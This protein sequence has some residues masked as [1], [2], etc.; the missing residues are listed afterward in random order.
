ML[1]YGLVIIGLVV[2]VAAWLVLSGEATVVLMIGGLLVAAVGA[3][4]ILRRT[5]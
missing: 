2:A 3:V 1:E 5:V 4:M